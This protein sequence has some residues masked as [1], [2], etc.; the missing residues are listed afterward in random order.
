MGLYDKTSWKWWSVRE[1]LSLGYTLGE[2]SEIVTKGLI[3]TTEFSSSSCGFISNLENNSMS[4]GLKEVNIS[5][6]LN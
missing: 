1:L 3:T 5:R 4:F 6:R 2:R